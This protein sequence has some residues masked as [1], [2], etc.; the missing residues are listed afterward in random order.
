MTNRQDDVQQA[1]AEAYT[2]AERKY[3]LEACKVFR[4]FEDNISE[5]EE[6][7]AEVFGMTPPFDEDDDEEG[8]GIAFPDGTGFWVTVK[9]EYDGSAGRYGSVL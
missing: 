5:L 8:P 4:Y 6:Q 3:E 1:E 2:V 7:L 9:V